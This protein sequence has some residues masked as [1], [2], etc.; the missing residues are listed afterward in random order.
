MIWKL[1]CVYLDLKLNIS[2]FD[3]DTE[4]G[5]PPESCYTAKE[6][7]S[8]IS[9]KSNWLDITEFWHIIS[10]KNMITI[11]IFNNHIFFLKCQNSVISA[12]SDFREFQKE[13]FCSVFS[14]TNVNAK[15]AACK[16][17]PTVFNSD[18][19]KIFF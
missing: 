14:G 15:G 7:I 5:F 19:L 12:P 1:L 16:L 18:S 13:P 9:E 2:D 8:E 11:I 4:V 10:E 17:R 6:V 3:V